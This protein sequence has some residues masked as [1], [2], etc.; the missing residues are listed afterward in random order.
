M[1]KL[2]VTL[3]VGL[4]AFASFELWAQ[5]QNFPTLTSAQYASMKKDDVYVIL[6]TQRGCR[7]CIHAKKLLPALVQQ[8]AS[9]SNVHVYLLKTDDDSPAPDGTYLY[10]QLGLSGVPSFVVLYND[11]SVFSRTGFSAGQEDELKSKIISVV[12]SVK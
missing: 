8:Y 1:K 6:F 7:P 10:N 3:F 11:T 2:I 5:S 9:E 4:L 12:A